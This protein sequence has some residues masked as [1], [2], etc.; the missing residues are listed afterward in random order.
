MKETR[1]IES[2]SIE[3][4]KFELAA[5]R[6]ASSLVFGMEDSIFHGTGI[7]YAQPRPYAP[8]DSIKLI[9]WKVTARTG[10]HFVKEYQETKRMP[11]YILLDT[12]ASMCVSSEKMSKYAWAVAL[13]AGLALS[14]QS[15]MMPAGLLGCGEQKLHLKPTLSEGEIMQTAHRLRKHGFLESTTL[16]VRLR[17]LAPS[18]NIHTIIVAIT[19]LHDPDAIPALKSVGQKHETIVLHLQDKAERGVRGAGLFRGQEAETG[20]RF[21]GHGRKNFDHSEE[22]KRE[23]VRRGVDYLLLNT[24]EP[25]L[26]KL[27]FFLNMRGKRATA[28]R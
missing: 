19:D 2:S 4:R 11:V 22:C 12:S 16:G 28:G 23:L 25:I 24:D 15:N 5:Q 3:A 21:T 14:A 18:L 10:K 13:G 17:E 6:L 7:E 20:W 9:D 26:P 8:G 27:Q 1:E